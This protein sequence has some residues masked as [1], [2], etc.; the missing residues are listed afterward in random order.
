MAFWA[1]ANN[2]IFVDGWREKQVDN[3]KT[4]YL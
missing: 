4:Y 3:F 1:F 2:D